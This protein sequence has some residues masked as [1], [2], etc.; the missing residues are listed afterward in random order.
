MDIVN[1][2]L[3]GLTFYKVDNTADFCIY[4]AKLHDLVLGDQN[5]YVLVFVQSHLAILNMCQIHELK[6]RNVQTRK[7]HKNKYNIPPQIYK[8]PSNTEDPIFELIERTQKHS[9]YRCD[10]LPDMA[11]EL[12]HDIR[13][14]TIYQYYG[15]ITLSSA[16]ATY[17]CSITLTH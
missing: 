15:K 13:K 6:W 10:I 1:I 3:S 2:Y 14:K 11:I 12:L 9:S 4:A 17:S 16:L 7:L 5:N 8:P